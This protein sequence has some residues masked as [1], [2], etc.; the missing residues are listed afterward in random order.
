[1]QK[2][3]QN[4]AVQQP[5]AIVNN[6]AKLHQTFGAGDVAHQG[7]LMLIG[8]SAL[9]RSARLRTNRQLAEGSSQGSR[10]VWERGEIYDAD[11]DEVARLIQKATKCLLEH[12]YVGP[13][14]VSPAD[15]TEN[16]LTHPEHGNQGFP[17]GC[18]LAVAYQRNLDAEQREQRVLD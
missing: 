4:R 8:I 15:P 16:D 5:E 6:A 7:D 2:V 13:V 3:T 11:P 12:G 1:M 14:I 9:P 17:A 10:H 18:I